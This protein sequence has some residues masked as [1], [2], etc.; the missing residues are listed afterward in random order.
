MIPKPAAQSFFLPDFL[1]LRVIV[2]PHVPTFLKSNHNWL[3]LERHQTNARQSLSQKPLLPRVTI[4]HLDG[5]GNQKQMWFVVLLTYYF[6]WKY[7]RVHLWRDTAFPMQKTVIMEH[8]M[9]AKWISGTAA[10]TNCGSCY[11]LCKCPR[12]SQQNRQNANDWLLSY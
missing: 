7:V 6:A 11:A 2:F 12:A 5:H 9:K 1:V 8:D 10:I 3:T 4:L